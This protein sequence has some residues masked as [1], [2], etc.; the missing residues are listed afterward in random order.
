M[1]TDKHVSFVATVLAPPGCFAHAPLMPMSDDN[2]TDALHQFSPDDSEARNRLLNM[3]HGE[4]DVIANKFNKKF[5]RIA[6]IDPAALVAELYLKLHKRGNL[7]DFNNRK[8]FYAYAAVVMRNFMIDYT[9][10]KHINVNF[11]SEE[12]AFGLEEEMSYHTLMD[13]NRCIDKLKTMDNRLGEVAEL[14]VYAGLNNKDLAEH[15]R[16]STKTISRDLDKIRDLMASL[17]KN[18]T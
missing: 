12:K 4:L 18:L 6:T 5:D 17:R 2:V 11:V 13:F 14:R 9:R 1:F 7:D 15:F 16:V 3:V 10:K 8:E